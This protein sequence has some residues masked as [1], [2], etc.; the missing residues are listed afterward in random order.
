VSGTAAVTTARGARTPRREAPAPDPWARFHALPEVRRRLEEFVGGP[1]L[2]AAG[3]RYLCPPVPPREE[4]LRRWPTAELHVRLANDPELARS[5]WDRD[6]LLVDLDL[7]HVHFDRPELPLL[8]PERSRALQRPTVRALGELLDRAGVPNLHLLTGRG[9]HLLWRIGRDSP[10]YAALARL[11]EVEPELAREYDA[12]HPPAGERVGGALGAAWSGLGKLLEHLAHR[13]L[14]RAAPATPIPIQLTAV[15]VGPGERGREI[16]S[17]DLSAYADP[18]HQRSVRMPFTA[19]RK[20]LGPEAR[21]EPWI[22]LPAAGE[23][24]RAAAAMR[25]FGA[26]AAWAGDASCAIPD[27]SAGTERLLAAYRRSPLAA[28]HRRFAAERAHPPASWPATYDR[29]DLDALPACAARVLAAPNDLLLQP[30]AMQLVLR[31]L[32]AR[33]WQARHVAGLI[34]SKLARPHGWVRDVHFHDA[35]LRAEVYMRIFAGL[36]ATGRDRLVD[37]NCRSTQEKGLCVEGGC[38][39]NLADLGGALRAE[40]HDA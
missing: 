34:R 24:E 37:F 32:L 35:G 9:H 36:I 12:P 30:A 31:A 27:G 2:A 26:A 1:P 14:A 3:A 29:L 18:L 23:V 13:A 15:A 28:F 38:P 33:G 7:E 20:P 40:G 11:G 19:Y 16:V 4:P 6:A 25:D 21:E 22:T 10:A 5:V 39:W 17:I 8:E